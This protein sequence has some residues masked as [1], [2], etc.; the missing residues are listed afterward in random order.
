M[1]WLTLL[2]EYLRFAIVSLSAH[3]LRSFLTTLG[4]IIGV[5]TIITIFTTIE[6]LNNYVKENFSSIGGTGSVYIS[7]HPWMMLGDWWKYRNRPKIT[8]KEYNYLKEHS[9]EASHIAP[10]ISITSTVQSIRETAKNVLVEA[11]NQDYLYL[12]GVKL[13]EGRFITQLDY[14]A[15]RPVAVIG[16]ELGELLFK[17]ENPLGKV[18]RIGGKHFKVVGILEK[19]GS[20][21]G[22]NMDK[23]VIVPYFALRNIIGPRRGIEI[24]AGTDDPKKLTQLKD[25]LRYL[26]RK[27]RGLKPTEPDNFSFNEQDQL[28][29]TYMKLTG[30]LYSIIFVIGSV[31]LLVGGI[32]IT[33]IMLVTVTERTKEIGIRK[34]IG[35][36]KGAIL[37]QFLF[38]AVIVALIG[39]IIGLILG[40]LGATQILNL[41][42]LE[43]IITVRTILVAI[44]FSSFV[45]VVSGFYPAFK[46]SRLNPIEALRYE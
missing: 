6:G 18:I 15:A 11:T 45:G 13:S 24:V 35:A 33:N 43:G 4:I 1:R 42:K 2:G 41:L 19:R 17:D 31:S 26:M 10:I 22:F 14:H 20:I 28:T 36:S 21:F 27:I 8:I 30:S 34:A 46:A 5:T 32:V 9:K 38:E 7:R 44:G 12:G 3:K 16:A 39:G 23:S 25:E 37:A 29:D 40:Y